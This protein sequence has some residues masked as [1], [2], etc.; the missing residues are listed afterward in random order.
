VIK[1]A[2][3]AVAGLLILAVTFGGGISL[4]ILVGRSDWGWLFLVLPAT[5]IVGIILVR[6]GIRLLVRG[7]D[8]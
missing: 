6:I 2:L 1:R 7:L 5:V 4:L 8:G 3:L